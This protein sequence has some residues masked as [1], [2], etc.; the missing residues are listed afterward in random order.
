[1]SW[2]AFKYHFARTEQIISDNNMSGHEKKWF[3]PQVLF[4]KALCISYDFNFQLF[5]FGSYHIEKLY[6]KSSKS[7]FFSYNS[8]VTNRPDQNTKFPLVFWGF[9]LA[10]LG[11]LGLKLLNSVR[12]D[13][14]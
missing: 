5:I 10:F 6:I 11:F 13:D 9:Y 12:I 14:F 3:R 8:D 1:M 2:N 7:H 4:L